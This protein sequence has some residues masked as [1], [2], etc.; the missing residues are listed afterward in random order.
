MVSAGYMQAGYLED[1]VLDLAKLLRGEHS[2]LGR[3]LRDL[4]CGELLHKI[5]GQLGV[6]REDILHGLFHRP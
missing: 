3:L 6:S 4:N 5:A 2:S 1:L